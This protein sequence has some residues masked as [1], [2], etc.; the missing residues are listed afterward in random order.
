M[1]SRRMRRA[2][3]AASLAMLLPLLS[4]PRAGAQPA[5]GPEDLGPRFVK[6]IQGPEDFEAARAAL[7]ESVRPDARAED[8]A[9][10]VARLTEAVSPFTFRSRGMLD[11]P[12]AMAAA[13]AAE[14]DEEAALPRDVE[15][16]SRD[17]AR[18]APH[19]VK[20]AVNAAAVRRVGRAVP[21]ARAFA[22][23]LGGEPT[24]EAAVVLDWMTH[25]SVL[26][27]GVALND[28]VGVWQEPVEKASDRLARTLRSTGAISVRQGGTEIQIGTGWVMAPGVVATNRHVALFFASR[29]SGAP[30]GWAI[31]TGVDGTPVRPTIDFGRFQPGCAEGSRAFDVTG[32]L[33]VED[34]Q[35]PDVALLQVQA[36][37]AAGDAIPPPLPLAT[38]QD[39]D[40][41]RD[42]L[43]KRTVYV[44]G[45]PQKSNYFQTEEERQI[46]QDVFDVK[47]ISFGYLMD[48]SSVD[49]PLLHDCQTLGGSSGSPLCDFSTGEVVGL[50]FNG[51]FRVAN[52]AATIWSILERPAV[53]AMLSGV[54]TTPNPV[55]GPAVPPETPGYEQL[56]TR[57]EQPPTRPEQPATRPERPAT[58]GVLSTPPT[59]DGPA[60]AGEE[61]AHKPA[62]AGEEG[63]NKPAKAG[64]NKPAKAEA[65]SSAVESDPPRAEEAGAVSPPSQPAANE[66]GASAPSMVA[67]DESGGMVDPAAFE[68]MLN[69]FG[70]PPTDVFILAHGWNNSPAEALS[71]YTR[72]MAL[73]RQA[74]DADGSRPAG[75]RPMVLGVR[76]PSKAWIND[77]REESAVAGVLEAGAG[78]PAGRSI[79]PRIVA[80]LY[81]NMPRSKA[82]E[83]QYSRDILRIQE[84]LT[85]PEPTADD[86]GEAFA[87]FRRYA[88]EG[89][90][91]DDVDGGQGGLESGPA[92]FADPRPE[93]GFSLL[94]SARVFTYWQMKGRAGL[95]G[96]NGVRVMLARLQARYPG[97]RIHLF[98]H[99]FGTKVVLA[100]VAER[101]LGLPR[102][103]TTL[104][105]IQG[106]VS[107]EAMS[108]RVTGRNVP[109]A[110]RMALDDRRVAGHVI[111]TFSRND[112]ALNDFYPIASRAAGQTGEVDEAAVSRFDA[113]GAVGAYGANSGLMPMQLSR[114]PYTFARKVVSVD[115]GAS[116]AFIGGHSDFF[117]AN[118][119][120]LFWSAVKASF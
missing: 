81:E 23:V 83:A 111:V 71:S 106:A 3:K 4:N 18:L 115:G 72:M 54:V 69:G 15:A 61:G 108:E 58:G 36:R 29:A 99:S 75:Y 26:V 56:P 11:A 41:L 113:L 64:S 25:P 49:G 120:W 24:E 63:A 14:S 42:R 31:S 112:S 97:A 53:A 80:A 40:A 38:T 109:G 66:A 60:E 95:V 43:D 52:T 21:E 8:G 57:P 59:A 67:F 9:A 110:Y 86:R 91:V 19:P 78:G 27:C 70:A 33:Y 116:A 20:Q 105:L 34:S 88:I 93:G 7:V 44:V 103:V 100:A 114:Q 118:V 39:R 37:N 76:W 30:S 51:Q 98:G 46:Y 84:L 96:R 10:P 90:F 65:S 5:S 101:D 12:T 35:N 119:A 32:I 45:Y 73:V 6:A 102:P 50:H 47:R 89:R 62:E 13:P 85:L 107:L 117:N 55:V 22:L 48:G 74:A 28:R 2:L 16:L 79:D 1:S 17:L 77:D 82:T 87:I 92:P 68:A 94:D 104:V